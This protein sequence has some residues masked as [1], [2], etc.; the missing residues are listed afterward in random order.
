MAAPV[1]RACGCDWDR[2][3]S[4]NTNLECNG[5]GS[6][7]DPAVCLG[8]TPKCRA[9]LQ[10]PRAQVRAGV[11]T[12]TPSPCTPGCQAAPGFSSLEKESHTER[13]APVQHSQPNVPLGFNF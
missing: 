12:G 8:K 7:H 3:G 11:G 1:L 6:V 4:A 9:G 2:G 10:N 5:R 13:G